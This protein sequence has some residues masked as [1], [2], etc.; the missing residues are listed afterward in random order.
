M[1]NLSRLLFRLLLGRRLPRAEGALTVPALR[2]AV[3]VRRD[4]WGVPHIDTENDRDGAFAVG[5][6]HGQD[7]A[8]QL[9]TLLRAGRGTLSELVGP[10]ALS[11]DRLSRRIGFHHAARQQVPVLSAAVRELLDAYGEGVTAG[12]TVGSTR[13]AHELALLRA[14]PTPWTAADSLAVVK[15]ISFTLAANWD[16][17]LARLRILGTD[18]PEALAALDPAYPHWHPVTKPPGQGA[19]PG[20]D[21]LAHDLAAFVGAVRSGGGSN[22]WAVA[23]ARTATGRPILANDPH[24][25]ASLPPHW[26]LV[27]VRTPGWAVAGATFLGGPSVLAGHNGRAAWGVTAGL[28]D[29]TDLFREQIGPD[30]TS[31]RQG[32]EFVPCPVR[33]EVIHV[34]G[35]EP[36]VERVLVTPRGPVISPALHGNPEA[37]SLRALWLDPLPIDGL[38][39][40]HRVGNFA[41]FR[42]A[43]AQWPA[44]TQNVAYADVSGVVGWQ[45]AGLAPRRRKGWG[46]IPQPGWDG[47][48]GWEKEPVPFEQ[49]PHLASP[50]CGYV[51]T[52]N[53]RPVPEGEGPYLGE[54]WLD[55]YRAASITRALAARAD[56]D[57]AATQQLQM[58]T[59]AL[60]WDDLRDAVL[61]APDKD[62]DA[63]RALELLRGWDGRAAVDSPAAAVYEVFLSEMTNRVAK[64]KAPRSY[65]AALGRSMSPLTGYNFFCFRRTGH[66]ARLL[67]E[68]P[69]GWFA[70][71][72]PAEVADALAAAV[73]RLEALRGADTRNWAWGE[74]RPLTL[75]HPFGRKALF[76]RVFNLGPVPYGG[77]ADTIQQASALPLDPLAHTDNIASLRVVIDVGGWENSRYALP[78]GQSGNPLSPHYDDLHPLWLRGEGVPIA[79]SEEAVRAA[80]VATLELKP[81]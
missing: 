23:G 36:V 11:I 39:R 59:Q 30:G 18:G 79:W 49:M 7:R 19:G 45:L 75:H 81:T 38:L 76:A 2:A 22:N 9:E 66:L 15:I 80:T 3:R 28:V 24:L 61:A 77:D 21:R 48:F 1:P 72:W 26:Y 67:R 53:N 32:G 74:V 42:A 27:H 8:F 78:A 35:G 20:L 73:R 70:R 4:R 63:R 52:A 54:D 51:A 46:L 50:E 33:E 31:V 62:A 43:L 14:R 17:E 57:V 55:G 40:L 41:E 58:S 5:F 71:P 56:W 68:R 16:V 25:D 37:L 60:A 69:S 34:K 47:E 64:A 65:D 13:R 29:N 6:C 12:A 10:D 44:S